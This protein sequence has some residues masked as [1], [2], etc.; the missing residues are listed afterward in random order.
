MNQQM[1]NNPKKRK[2][3]TAAAWIGRSAVF[4]A[5]YLILAVAVLLWVQL[6]ARVHIG[7]GDFPR[8]STVTAMTVPQP[9]AA[10]EAIDERD[11]IPEREVYTYEFLADLSAYEQYMEPADADGYIQLINHTHK[12]DESYI[13]ED[14]TDIAN[15]RKD[16][17]ATQQMRLT[18]A[19]ALEALFLEAA[20]H[21][22]TDVT[23][24][25]GYRSYAYQTQLYEARVQQYLG[26]GYS[27]AEARKKAAT[28]VT[29]PGSSEHQSGLCVDMHNIASA[30][31][32][33]EHKEAAKWLKDNCYKFGFI[34]RYPKDKTDVTGI[35]FEPWHFRFVGR[36]HASKMHELGMCLEEYVPYFEAT[37]Q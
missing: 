23:V 10:V 29:Y 35:S 32:S 18:A 24:T 25:S 11:A 37:Y 14:L 13:P 26:Y 28:I 15:T 3:L 4:A 6:N 36:F 27:D 20:E 9:D 12:L 2:N 8:N 21:G 22:I 17:R 5:T 7:S 30:D 33:F 19:K 1:P 34:L 16:G 31:V